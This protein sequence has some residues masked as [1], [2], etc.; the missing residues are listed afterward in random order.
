MPPFGGIP[1][2]SGGPQKWVY[3]GG[4]WRGQ[5]YPLFGPSGTPSQGGLPGGPGGAPGGRFW[6][7][8]RPGGDF[9]PPEN[10]PFL[11]LMPTSVPTGRVIKYPRKCTP[12]GPRAPGRPPGGTPAQGGRGPPPGGSPRGVRGPPKYPL[13]GP[14]RWGVPGGLYTPSQDPQTGGP[15]GT[16]IPGPTGGGPGGPD[17]G[18]S[19]GYDKGGP[20]PR[21]TTCGRVRVLTA[22]SRPVPDWMCTQRSQGRPGALPGQRGSSTGAVRAPGRCTEA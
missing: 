9:W 4:S 16:C 6:A 8:G 22:P 10:H 20:G 2:G 13:P 3:F 17:V 14:P 11:F 19:V 15:G 21:K 7:P 5:K 12:P 18:H 1:G